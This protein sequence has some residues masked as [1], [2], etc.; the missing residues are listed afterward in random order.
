MADKYRQPF[1][2]IDNATSTKALTAATDRVALKLSSSFTDRPPVSLR[3]TVT[4]TDNARL[5]FGDVTVE[6]EQTDML[7]LTGTTEIIT[8]PGSTDDITYV[9]GE[10]DGATGCSVDITVGF[11]I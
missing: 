1:T 5:A 3:I 6:A 7:F 10:S 8:L 11:G 9:A 2:P 4:G